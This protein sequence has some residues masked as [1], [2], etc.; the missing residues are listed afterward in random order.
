MSL[1]HPSA[2]VM[3]ELVAHIVVA[4]GADK[5]KFDPLVAVSPGPRTADRL[6]NFLLAAVPERERPSP[7]LR[8][9]MADAVAVLLDDW[10]ASPPTYAAVLADIERRGGIARLAHHS[11]RQPSARAGETAAS[12]L[13]NC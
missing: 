2:D 11:H 3:A 4:Y 12:A 8:S 7:A 1:R 10:H 6:V 13:G 5:A 9:A